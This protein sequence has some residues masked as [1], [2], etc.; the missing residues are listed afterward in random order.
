M[1][2]R[3]HSV[4]IIRG[5]IKKEIKQAELTQNFDEMYNLFEQYESQFDL[6]ENLAMTKCNMLYQMNAFLELREEA[7]IL[8]K[9]V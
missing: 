4:S 5:K 6:D 7:I 9:K 2:V 1:N 3:Y 8:L